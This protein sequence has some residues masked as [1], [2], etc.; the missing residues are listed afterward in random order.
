VREGDYASMLA[1][2]YGLTREQA[3]AANAGLA[4]LAAAD[5][6]RM[7]FSRVRPGNTFDAH[8]LLHAARAAGLADALEGRVFAAYFA[9]GEAVG[10]HDVLVRLAADVGM[11]EAEARDVLSSDRFADDVR[12]DEADAVALGVTGVPF[13]VIDHR[14][15]VPGAQD[16]E[17]LRRVLERAGER[18]QPAVGA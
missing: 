12:R 1:R 17:T 11:D 15:C 18:S 6:V 9:E 13:F 4:E 14:F 2:K 8:R 7:D 5:G 3:L 10:D 16:T